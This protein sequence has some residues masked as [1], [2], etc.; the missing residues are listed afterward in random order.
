MSSTED[1]IRDQ[2]IAAFE[3][4]DYPVENQMELVPALPN[5]PGTKFEAGDVSVT[6]ME[7][8]TKLS[9]YQEFPYEDVETMVDDAL[10]G[11]KET[12][13]L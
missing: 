11:M 6:A 12:G 8:A 3:G 13:I 1:E 9:S 5:G 7:L 10:A 2:L 4:A